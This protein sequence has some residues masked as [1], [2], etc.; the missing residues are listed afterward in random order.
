MARVNIPETLI[1]AATR[2][3]LEHLPGLVALDGS[4]VFA[5]KIEDFTCD[6]TELVAVMD[7]SVS[8]GPLHTE[9]ASSFRFSISL[10][11]ME[12]AKPTRTLETKLPTE[13]D[14]S[15]VRIPAEMLPAPEQ[16]NVCPACDGV[17]GRGNADPTC[18][19]CGGFGGSSAHASS[20]VG[21]QQVSDGKPTEL[22]GKPRRYPPQGV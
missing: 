18:M 6:P 1:K 5:V 15:S 9:P 20:P 19:A 17:S 21:P 14:F 12:D 13:F 22:R 4:S 10:G 7:V 8:D 11:F 16:P 2:V 3:L